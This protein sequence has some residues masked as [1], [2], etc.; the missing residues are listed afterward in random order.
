MSDQD[1]TI[2]SPEP[3]LFRADDALKYAA[4]LLN[5]RAEW[6]NRSIGGSDC[7][8]DHDVELD[9]ISA[10]A[11]QVSKIAAHFGDPRRYSDGRLVTSLIQD[12]GATSPSTCGIPTRQLRQYR[13][14]WVGCSNF[15]MSPALVNKWR[16][17]APG[18]VTHGAPPA[19]PHGICGVL[20]RIGFFFEQGV[21]AGRH[22]RVEAAAGVTGCHGRRR[23]GPGHDG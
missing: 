3:R 15:P 14:G 6:I 7:D 12:R 5:Y 1:R 23:R 2:N 17:G 16:C 4:A 8:T 22:D 13:R 20:F 10:I 21:K 11:R 19:A 9:S 18:G